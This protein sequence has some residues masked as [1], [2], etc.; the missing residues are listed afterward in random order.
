M[1]TI[2]R[3]SSPALRKSS[4]ISPAFFDS[5]SAIRGRISFS[6]NSCAARAICRCSSSKRSGAM[7]SRVADRA[8]RE[9]LRRRQ[10]VVLVVHRG[11]S[12]FGNRN[13]YHSEFFE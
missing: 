4:G 3:P 9:N 2:N 10:G 6:E 5:I 13:L 11:G 12:D 8:P 7:I 1:S